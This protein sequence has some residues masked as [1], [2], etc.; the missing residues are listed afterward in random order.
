[1]RV[2]R[3]FPEHRLKRM[4]AETLPPVWSHSC[5]SEGDR[6]AGQAEDRT[7]RCLRAHR[8]DPLTSTFHPKQTFV[9]VFGQEIALIERKRPDYGSAE[10]GRFL[11]ACRIR[12]APE[13]WAS[14]S[15]RADFNENLSSS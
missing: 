2:V 13:W 14:A 12:P 10:P 5:R 6:P 4:V 9:C 3:T 15:L 8:D 1:M 7:P 11:S